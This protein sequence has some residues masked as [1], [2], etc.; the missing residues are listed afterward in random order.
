[1]WHLGTWSSGGLVSVGFTIGLEDLEG[2]LQP[3]R[4]YDSMQHTDGLVIEVWT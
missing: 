2:L 1:M 4:F 3:K